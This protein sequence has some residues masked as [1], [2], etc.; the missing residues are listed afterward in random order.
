MAQEWQVADVKEIPPVKEDWPATW[1]SIRHY[2]GITAFGI[3][4]VSKDAGNVLIPEHD[5]NQS[6]QQEVYFVHEGEA[7]ATLDG[8]E[9]NMPAGWAVALEPGVKRTYQPN[10]RRRKRRHGFRAR[11]AT[12]AGRAILKRRRAKGRKRLSA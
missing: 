7:K 1:K 6:N 11:M 10:V 12:R 4:A 5:E 8:E 3:N 2:F 9:V